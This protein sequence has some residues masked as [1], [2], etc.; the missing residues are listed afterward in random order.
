VVD[1]GTTANTKVCTVTVSLRY[2]LTS[3]ATALA[4]K[5]SRAVYIVGAKR[6][7][8]GSFGGKL[9]SL[10]TTDLGVVAGSAAL[11]A[12]NV[13]PTA[14]DHVVFGNVRRHVYFFVGGSL[15][16]SCLP[17]CE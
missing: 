8:I 6:T 2:S 11:K 15:L 1:K 5:A 10:T 17:F 7:P 4:S 16:S 9:K 3:V 13:N 12:A 14:V